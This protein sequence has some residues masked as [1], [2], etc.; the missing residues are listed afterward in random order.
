[1]ASSEKG[2]R[3]GSRNS[4]I[5][6][7]K[8]AGLSEPHRW[9]RY[10]LRNSTGTALSVWVRYSSITA[11]EELMKAMSRVPTTR[12][13]S[14]LANL[15]LADSS[16]RKKKRCVRSSTLEEQYAGSSK[17]SDSTPISSFQ[18]LPQ[19]SIEFCGIAC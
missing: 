5:S 8:V 12:E 13:P 14:E 19:S 16:K 18:S 11:M 2:S 9:G 3:S 10:V 17:Q 7:Q 15:L 4:F 1:M 6:W